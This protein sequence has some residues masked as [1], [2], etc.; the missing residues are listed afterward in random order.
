[1][2]YFKLYEEFKKTLSFI[3]DLDCLTFYLSDKEIGYVEYDYDGSAISEHLPKEEKEFYLA[4]IEVYPE[5]RGL[6]YSSQ[7][8]DIVKK[9]AKELGATII[10]LKVDYGMGFGS[11][12]NP[13]KSLEKLYL[14]KGFKYS[15]TEDEC[16]KDDTKS[17]GAMHHPL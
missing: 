5:Y 6:D 7:M 15:F 3:K 10:T 14:S 2:K 17:L 11:K 1:M 8:I 9:Y 13:E 4:M 12:R 16:E